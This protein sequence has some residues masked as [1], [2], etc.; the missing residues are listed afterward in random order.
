M[1]DLVVPGRVESAGDPGFPAVPAARR[2]RM[3][4]AGVSDRRERFRRLQARPRG[5]K[6]SDG[7]GTAGGGASD[8]EATGD[9]F[10]H[11]GVA[12]EPAV[13]DEPLTVAV[14]AAPCRRCGWLLAYRRDEQACL[15][16]GE[17]DPLAP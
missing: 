10:E 16:C 13:S 14:E 5:G 15:A 11:F 2:P 7:A 8:R 9:L 1:C 3:Y 12:V 6:A 4:S 17:P